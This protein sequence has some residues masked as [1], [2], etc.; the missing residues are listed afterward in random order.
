MKM[1]LLLA[2]ATGAL[3][4]T[5]ANAQ[6]SGGPP[7]AYV[8]VGGTSQEIYLV[9]ANGSGS[10]RLYA[11]PRKTG[12]ASIDM[13]PGGNE[14]AFVETASGTPRVLKVLKFNNAGVKLG[15]PVSVPNLCAPDYVDYNPVASEPPTV[16]ISE[17][18]NGIKSI[19]SIRT[20]GSGR[21]VLQQGPEANVYVAQPRWLKDGISYVYV[22][23][24]DNNPTQQ[25][26]CRN[27]CDAGSG[28]LLWTGP[29][30]IWMDVGRND[31][32]ILFNPGTNQMKMID[33]DTG[34]DLTPSLFI[35]GTG[36]HF[37]PDGRYVLYKTPHSASGDYLHIYDTTTGLATRL[38]GK[39][40]Y[41]PSDW[42]K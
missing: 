40:E 6:A 5:M 25:Q 36:G 26:L 41:G 15:D 20:D 23:A 8:K 32:R 7:I 33:G 39:G 28:E 11:A 37:S 13:R 29:Q 22:R 9:N 1:R 16:I 21:T 12:L 30:V 31:N 27:A 24:L 19:I 4:T 2:A 18:C 38:T 34:S 17:V 42:R 10:T 35:S 3:L 14:I